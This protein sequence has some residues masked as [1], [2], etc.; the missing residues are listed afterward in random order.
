MYNKIRAL[1]DAKKYIHILSTQPLVGS[2]FKL[3]KGPCRP[4]TRLVMRAHSKPPKLMHVS[5][6][7]DLQTKC[8]HPFDGCGISLLLD[9]LDQC[10]SAGIHHTLHSLGSLSA[11]G[12]I[13]A[14][15]KECMRF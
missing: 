13:L 1:G 4:T 7:K 11:D 14:N 15:V 2:A 12:D 10:A 9:G 5:H 6:Q 8:L 3:H